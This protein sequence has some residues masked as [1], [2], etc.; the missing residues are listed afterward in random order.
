MKNKIIV[1]FSVIFIS[2]SS[3]SDFL[4]INQDPNVPTKPEIEKLLP[5]I[6]REVG[7]IFS[8]RFSGINNVTAVYVHHL[9]TRESIDAYQV[10][11]GDYAIR[12]SWDAT[13][14]ESLADI[15]VLMS[16][17][18]ADGDGDGFKDYAAYAGI[19]KIFKAYVYSQL[20]DLWGDIPFS[21]A[22]SDIN[23][24]NFNPVFDDDEQIYAALFSLLEEGIADLQ[25][26]TSNNFLLPADD[27]IIYGGSINKWIRFANTVRLKLYNQVRGTAL[28]NESVVTSLLTNKGD[29]LMAE[30]GDFWMPYGSSNAPDNRH[31]GFVSDYEGSQISMYCSPWFY[32]ILNGE[33]ARIFNGITDPRIPYYF[34]NQLSGDDSEAPPEYRNGDFMSIYFGSQGINRDHSARKSATQVGIYPVGGRFDD[35]RG[36]SGTPD[37][38]TGDAPHRFLSYSDCLFIQAELAHNGVAGDPKALLEEAITK[39]FEQV[40]KVVAMTS[41]T[42]EVPVLKGSDELSDYVGFVMS[43]YDSGDNN[44][45]LEI[46]MTQKWISMFGGNETDCYTDY[47]RTGYPVLFDANN[48]VAS[49]GPDGSGV[50]PTRVDRDYPLS[51]PYAD[52]ELDT[53]DNAPA[54]K[55]I[56]TDGIFWDN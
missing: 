47:R 8:L 38:A 19:A 6:I 26:D 28:W 36:G 9:T 21:E 52:T 13:Y 3:C 34:Y 33:N 50:V 39:S 15:E 41:T 12:T 5:G 42:Q 27:D 30:G 2:L 35:G 4:D 54:Q 55:N 45:K 24:P 53:N 31:P 43:E 17:A 40:D 25:D 51:M 22:I 23:S 16:L 48:D 18:E 44:K 29:S 46:I 32:E 56:T 49:G 37:N 14:V 11:A 7:D 20:V 10:K 1:L